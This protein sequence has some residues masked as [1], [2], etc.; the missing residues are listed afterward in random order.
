M[1][2]VIIDTSAWIESFRHKSEKTFIN[3][4]KYL[5]LKRRVMVLG[6][7]KTKLLRIGREMLYL[8]TRLY[9]LLS[10]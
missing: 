2:K 9:D 1:D 7:V 4:V 6:T 8:N 5:I 10:K 3:L